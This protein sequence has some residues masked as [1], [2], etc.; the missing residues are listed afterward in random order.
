[1]LCKHGP[2]PHTVPVLVL[3]DDVDFRA[4]LIELLAD[5]GVDVSACTSYQSLLDA[6][7]AFQ[8]AVVLADFWGA[9][10]TALSPPERD[11][12]RELGRHAPTILLTG[13]AWA[14]A[15]TPEELDVA[16][17]L[18]KPIALDELVAQLVRCMRVAATP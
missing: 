1:M 14:L 3:E 5:E 4:L 13:R 8:R 17:I 11:E 2:P 15:I 6:V 7:Y 10:H 9:S 18:P 16:C 12:I